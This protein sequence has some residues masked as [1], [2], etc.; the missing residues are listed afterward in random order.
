MGMLE[1]LLAHEAQLLLQMQ[2]LD[3]SLAR[4]RTRIAEVRNIN[5]N[6][7]TYNL[8][9]ETLSAIFEA[10]LSNTSSSWTVSPVLCFES[11]PQIPFEV[12][13]SSVSRR[14]RNVALQTSRLWTDLQIIVS[15]PVEDLIDLYLHRSKTCLLDITFKEVLQGNPKRN[16]DQ[17]FHRKNSIRH[18]ERLIPHV[19]RWRTLAIED[20]RVGCLSTALSPLSDLCSPALERLRVHCLDTAPAIIEVLSGGAPLL[21]SLESRGT[22]IRPPCDSI[23]SLEMGRCFR[24]LTHKE[25]AQLTR[26]M[27]SLTHL[28]LFSGAVCETSFHPPIALLAVL[29]LDLYLIS[30]SVGALRFLDLPAVESLTVHGSTDHVIIAFTRHNQCYPAVRTLRISSRNDETYQTLPIPT[31]T[32]NFITLLPIVREV[33]LDGA[34][35]TPILH[36]LQNSEPL[37]PQLSVIT[38]VSPS[39]ANGSSQKKQVWDDVV[40]VV[41]NRL[42]LRLPISRIRLSSQIL[43]GLTHRQQQG[44]RAKVTLEEC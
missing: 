11:K 41:G 34:N 7:I 19:A 3:C 35:S 44:L 30:P 4:T 9:N 27:R 2:E 20:I 29:S 1:D 40:K 8:P 42:K 16:P 36:A 24:S 33:T 10:G 23:K 31:T 28:S 12:L 22:Y 37:W 17:D 26:P 15:K 25:F 14:W 43:K 21:S 38:I 39:G 18:L 6:A 32:R 5:R 13:V